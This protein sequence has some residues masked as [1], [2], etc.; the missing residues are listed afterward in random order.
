MHQ[1]QAQ[2]FTWYSEHEDQQETNGDVDHVV[3]K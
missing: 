1:T 3:A 2:Q